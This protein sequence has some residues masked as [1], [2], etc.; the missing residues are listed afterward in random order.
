MKRKIIKQGH[1]TLT[2]TLPSAWVKRFNLSS[3][4]EININEKDNGLFIS[5]EKYQENKRA[6]IDISNMDVP[7]IWK[8]LMAVYREGYDEVLIKFQPESMIENPYKFFC[9]HKLDLKYK[10]ESQKKP[11]LEAIQGFVSRF[12]GFE[13]I[14]HGKDFVLIREMGEPSSKE[15]DNSLRRVFLIVEQMSEETLEAITTNNPKILMRMHDVD[16][17]LDKFQDYCVRILNKI[18]N[19]EPRKASLLFSIIYFLE[20]IGDEFKTMS[21]HLVYDFSEGE[22]SDIKDIGESINSQIKLFYE[23][24]Y[25]YDLE[26]VEKISELDQK[27]YFSVSEKYKTCKNE[28]TKEIFHHLRVI[29]RY[30]NSLVELRIEMEF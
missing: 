1:S 4:K 16:I 10:R 2:I 20:L 3:G 5:A 29:S 30:L 8:Y 25:K 17:N 22:W 18:G 26:K 24:F 7:T 14:E 15:F 13:I 12:I 11:V 6:E 27:R 28:E 23:L 19:K 9:T 21:H